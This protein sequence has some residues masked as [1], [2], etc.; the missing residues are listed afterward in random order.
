MSGNSLASVFYWT[1]YKRGDTEGKTLM[2]RSHTILKQYGL[3]LTKAIFNNVFR[4]NNKSVIYEQYSYGQNGLVDS[5]RAIFNDFRFENQRY[6]QMLLRFEFCFTVLILFQILLMYFDNVLLN[7]YLINNNNNNYGQ[8]IANIRDVNVIL[9]QILMRLYFITVTQLGLK[10][11]ESQKRQRVRQPPY[12]SINKYSFGSS[13]DDTPQR[14]Q[15]AVPE[16]KR[17]TWPSVICSLAQRERGIPE[18]AVVVHASD[19]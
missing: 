15:V 14:A 16:A 7:A 6:A 19:C 17:S 3:T 10:K 1:I 2:G 9:C 13:R 12:S 18:F 8:K 5:L 11:Y 4:I